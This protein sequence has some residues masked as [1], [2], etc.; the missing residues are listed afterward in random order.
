M[1]QL[2][3]LYQTLL[4]RKPNND[5]IIKFNKHKNIKFANNQ[6]IISQEYKDFIALT[7][8]NNRNYIKC[9]YARECRTN[10]SNSSLSIYGIT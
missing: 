8:K 2:F 7:Q 4:N 1:N 5:E 6:I 9:I 3:I 10:S